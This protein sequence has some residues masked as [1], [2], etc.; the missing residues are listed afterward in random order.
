MQTEYD[1]FSMSV[2]EV[3]NINSETKVMRIPGGWIYTLFSN[4]SFESPVSSVF[5][6]YDIAN[7]D[8]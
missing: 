3:K 5:V 1:L 4:S 2:F 8:D 6:P 7:K